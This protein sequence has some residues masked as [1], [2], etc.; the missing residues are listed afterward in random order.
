[1][2]NPAVK[3]LVNMQW[4]RKKLSVYICLNTSTF[5]VACVMFW[6]NSNSTVNSVAAV[7]WCLQTSVEWSLFSFQLSRGIRVKEVGSV[8][9][10]GA[11]RTWQSEW[12][13]C[14]G[15]TSSCSCWFCSAMD[16]LP[17]PSTISFLSQHRILVLGLEH[18]HANFIFSLN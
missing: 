1:M 4:L 6:R 14:H 3:H 18:G 10:D 8:M 15:G 13:P 5:S 12:H 2:V 9:L 17:A 16:T 11:L 7:F